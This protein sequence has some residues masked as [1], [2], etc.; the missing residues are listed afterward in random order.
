MSSTEG[1]TR[2]NNGSQSMSRL[3]FASVIICAITQSSPVFASTITWG[4]SARAFDGYSISANDFCTGMLFSSARELQTSCSVFNPHG[5]G[6]PSSSFAQAIAN[7]NG[8]LSLSLE[9]LSVRAGAGGEASA[10]FTDTVTFKGVG[11]VPAPNGTV[12]LALV[13]SGLT[14][15]FL[16]GCG[17][18]VV[19]AGFIPECDFNNSLVQSLVITSVE[20]SHVLLNG[21]S[22]SGGSIVNS[23]PKVRLTTDQSIASVV[24]PAPVGIWAVP[25]AVGDRYSFSWSVD[26]SA[27]YEGITFLGSCPSVCTGLIQ[28]DFQDPPVIILLDSN[29][30]I[31]S[32]L[33]IDYSG[34]SP[35]SVVPE[36]S[37]TWP[38]AFVVGLITCTTCRKKALAKNSALAHLWCKPCTVTGPGRSPARSSSIRFRCEDRGRL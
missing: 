25:F 13:S 19:Q 15:V 2:Q 37:Y 7:S 20:D 33:G 31:S 27:T 11:P 4:V 5:T 28:A 36:P 29:V 18:T 3:W 9:N 21:R 38:I 32:E 22:G 26:V 8:I 1:L 6:S 14:G 12:A 34:S 10:T 17:T 24:V 23:Y 35:S 16:D 30:G